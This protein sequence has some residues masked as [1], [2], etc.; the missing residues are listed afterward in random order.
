VHS[1]IAYLGAVAGRETIAA[2]MKIPGLQFAM[3]RFIAEDVAHSLVPPAGVSVVEYGEEVLD[4][5]ANPAIEYRTVQ[6]ATD[7]SQ[8]LPQRVL[9]TI[10]DRRSAGASPRWAALV[11]AAWI[12]YAQGVTDDGREL[13]LDDPLADEIRSRLAAAPGTPAGAAGALLGLDAVIP[14]GLLGDEVV[15]ALVVEWLTAFEKHG[16]ESTLAGL[17]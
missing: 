4:R 6:V 16:V 5:F 1:A 13:P 2:A 10:L 3:R 9:P 14:A 8:K 15:Y 7:G 12:R 17:R 11:M